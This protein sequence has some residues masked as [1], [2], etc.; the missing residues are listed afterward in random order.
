MLRGTDERQVKE[1]AVQ[2]LTDQER[3]LQTLAV[4]NVIE[5]YRTLIRHDPR[6]I[7]E[8]AGGLVTLASSIPYPLFNPAFLTRP[9]GDPARLAAR[10]RDF[11][12][13]AGHP[14]LLLA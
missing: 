5:A 8:E 4:A 2:E 1:D 13:R 6:G 14:G 9:G 10:V 12:A 7:I 11:Y 3:A